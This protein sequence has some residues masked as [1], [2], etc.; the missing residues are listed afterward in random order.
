MADNTH[1]PRAKRVV[2]RPLTAAQKAKLEKIQARMQDSI[3]E[4]EA[5]AP[6]VIAR[7]KAH[8]ARKD[9]IL[10]PLRMAIAELK[11]NREQQGLSLSDVQ[12]RS[13]IDKATLSKLEN[14]L[15][16]NPTIST[17][18]RVAEALDREIYVMIIQK[19]AA[20]EARAR[21]RERVF[22]M[23]QAKGLIARAE[24]MRKAAD[25][26]HSQMPVPTVSRTEIE[27]LL[28]EHGVQITDDVGPRLRYMWVKESKESRVVDPRL[29]RKRVKKK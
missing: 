15:Q 21:S 25:V 6:E 23:L 19:P 17:L 7:A 29:W 4:A 9:A 14:D 18:I 27:N 16:G 13:G 24:S 26:L 11:A 2:S 28:A 22:A 10:A 3:R 1:E 5:E 8:F 12:A 20:S